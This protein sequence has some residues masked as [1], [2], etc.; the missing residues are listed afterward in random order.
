MMF[1]RSFSKQENVT[2][3]ALSAVI[4]CECHPVSYCVDTHPY[5]LDCVV[6][7][8][9]FN[10]LSMICIDLLSQELRPDFFTEVWGTSIDF[11]AP[12]SAAF[13]LLKL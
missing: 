7:V 12:P 11:L 3:S 8:F 6:K 5:G 13:L 9:I 1:F 2:L 4:S 10:N